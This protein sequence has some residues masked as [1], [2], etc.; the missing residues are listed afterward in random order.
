MQCAVEDGWSHLN[1]LVGFDSI[2]FLFVTWAILNKGVVE[3][4]TP[5]DCRMSTNKVI[6]LL[7][8]F[9]AEFTRD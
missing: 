4:T 3:P 5:F 9:T 8:Q 1:A 2:K 6:F 7:N